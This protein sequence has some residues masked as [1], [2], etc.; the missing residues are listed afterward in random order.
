MKLGQRFICRH[1]AQP[2]VGQ[3]HLYIVILFLKKLILI[4]LKDLVKTKKHHYFIVNIN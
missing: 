2:I 3:E 1:K 4:N